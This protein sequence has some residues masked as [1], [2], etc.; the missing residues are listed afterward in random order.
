MTY[1]ECEDTHVTR[2]EALR[3]L[4]HHGLTHEEDIAMRVLDWLGH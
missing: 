2:R 3:E 1:E 4:K